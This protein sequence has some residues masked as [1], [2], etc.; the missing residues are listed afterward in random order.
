MSESNRFRKRRSMLQLAF[1]ALCTMVGISVSG[2]ARAAAP[3]VPTY[4]VGT[5]K[6]GSQKG[7]IDLQIVEAIPAAGYFVGW[8]DLDGVSYLAQIQVNGRNIS[9]FWFDAAD[10]TQTPLGSLTG[11][12]SRDL[13]S[14]SGVI[15][16]GKRKG[17]FSMLAA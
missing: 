1:V 6:V 8:I 5:Y 9:A 3:G 2:G 12:V 13:S 15:K 7:A 14:F 17:K 10:D 16:I 11:S 4:F